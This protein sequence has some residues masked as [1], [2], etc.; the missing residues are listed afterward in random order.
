M[1]KKIF[2]IIVGVSVFTLLI[3]VTS[4]GALG[5]GI[6]M[7]KTINFM[8]NNNIELNYSN[9]ITSSD[10]EDIAIYKDSNSSQ[11]FYKNGDLVAYINNESNSNL[12]L[13][14]L[15]SNPE[16]NLER[17]ITTAKNYANS[18]LINENATIDDYVLTDYTYLEATKEYSYVFLKIIDGY[19]VNDGIMISLNE[20]GNLLTYS[21]AYQGIYD[22]YKNIDI[23]ENSVSE[24]VE[25]SMNL[26][27][28]NEYQIEK[29]YI[30]FVNNSLVLQIGIK[31]IHNDASV[32]TET[33]YYPL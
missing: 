32:S 6:E 30:N 20:N 24:F 8:N 18:F 17:Y 27:T 2:K 26:L 11:Y 16:T 33:L 5:N 10:S 29:E 12:E 9:K 14:T 28:S 7:Q 21:G 19:L 1:K 13:M 23:D 25:D 22:N 3:C 31:I 15:N 4:V